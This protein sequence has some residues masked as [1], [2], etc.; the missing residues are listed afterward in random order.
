MASPSKE[1]NVLKLLMENSPLREWHFEEISREAKITKAV[2]NKWLKK[3]ISEGLIKHNK[4]KG[5]FPFYSVGSDNPV[6][7]SLKR[8][9]IIKQLHD[10]GL[11]PGLISLDSAKTI[12]LFGSAA[13]GDWY[14]N[15]DIDIFILGNA[16]DFDKKPY[17]EKLHMNIELHTFQDRDEINDVKTGLIKNVINGYVIKGQIQD[18]AEVA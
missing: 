7:I 3:C 1:D 12:I 17:E 8:L 15:S 10:S 4:R 11:I 18:I 6:Y 2:A 14:K 13:R 9:H 5:K 16:S